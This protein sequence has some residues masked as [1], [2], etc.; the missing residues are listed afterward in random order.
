MVNFNLL[1]DSEWLEYIQINSPGTRLSLD[2]N[3]IKELWEFDK[4][5]W[6]YGNKKHTLQP[7]RPPDSDYRIQIVWKLVLVFYSL[8]LTKQKHWNKLNINLICDTKIIY[9]PPSILQYV[10]E[11]YFFGSN[12]LYKEGQ[13]F[14]YIQYWYKILDMY[15]SGPSFIRKTQKN[16]K[17]FTCHLHGCTI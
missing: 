9:F 17:I 12:L 13:N 11:V 1:T 7:L 6:A 8:S 16:S 4:S 2:T 10:Q 14:L 5:S 15:F 3:A